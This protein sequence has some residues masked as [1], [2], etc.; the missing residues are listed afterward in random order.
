MWGAVCVSFVPFVLVFHRVHLGRW[1]G[2]LGLQDLPECW[3]W[4]SCR[5]FP[6]FCP[7]SRFVFG[8]LYLNMPLFRVLR[9]FLACFGAFVWVCV[10]CVLCVACVALYACGV[11]RFKGLWRVLP[12]VFF[13]CSCVCLLLCSLSFF[14]LVIF[15][16]P[17]ALSLWLFGCG[18]C[19]LFPFG[20][21]AKRKGAKGC[22]CVL[23]SCVVGLFG[24]SDSCNV[25]EELRGRCFGSF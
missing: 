25:I 21:H 12:F 19:F 22:P 8:A 17:L 2:S 24:C 10:A 3:L 1:S 23:S 13:F 7:L 5:V 16:C 6:P 4:S 14:A 11:R 18:C 15:L 9:A 20:L